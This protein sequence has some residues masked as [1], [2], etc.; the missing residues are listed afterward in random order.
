MHFR[1]NLISPGHVQTTIQMNTQGISIDTVDNL[2]IAFA[3]TQ[4]GKLAIA[5]KMAEAPTTQGISRRRELKLLRS[6][7]DHEPT[8]QTE[9]FALLRYALRSTV[10]A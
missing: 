10:M 1:T 2:P 7:P 6:L 3:V 4:H 5:H 9:F 8:A